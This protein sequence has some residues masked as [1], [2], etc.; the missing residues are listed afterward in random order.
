MRYCFIPTRMA[1]LKKMESNCWQGHGEIGTLLHGWRECKMVQPLWMT[2]WWFLKKLN[3]ELPNDPAILLPK[4]ILKRTENRRSNKN[5]Y[6][7]VHST[8]HNSQR[9]KQPKCQPMNERINKKWYIHTMEYYSVIKK[10]QNP[11]TC[12]NMD[13]PWKHYAK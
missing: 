3:T 10:E 11:D 12:Y 6:T 13:E 5:L 7:N 8:I 4:D 2:V 1:M 9:Q